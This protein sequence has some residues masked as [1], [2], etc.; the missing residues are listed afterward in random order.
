MNW[1][2]FLKLFIKLS[3]IV[4]LTGAVLLGGVIYFYPGAKEAGELS[5]EAAV[6]YKYGDYEGAVECYNKLIELI[7][8][9]GKLYYE[10][11]KCYEALGDTAKAQA[12]FDKAKKLGYNE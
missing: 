11:G 2:K 10:R 9:S 3:A 8:K 1:K 5:A 6:S 12:D 4:A 7:P